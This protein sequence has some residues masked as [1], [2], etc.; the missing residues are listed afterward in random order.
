MAAQAL[1]P[2]DVEALLVDDLAAAGVA[3]FAPPAPLDLAS[4]VPCAM[5]ERA[6]GSRLNDVMDAH[7]VTVQAWGRDMG[8]GHRARQPH[9]GRD[10]APA[11]RGGALDAVE[12]LRRDG[13]PLRSPRPR[14][15]GNPARA[16]ERDALLPRR[17]QKEDE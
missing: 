16:A 11:A 8:R 6:G 13:A 7:D 3:A 2:V 12:A 15:T 10:R 9:S 1:E 5:V 17:V 14:P 4:R